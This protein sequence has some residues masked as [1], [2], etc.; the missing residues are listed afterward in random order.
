MIERSE[1]ELLIES[2]KN[3][4]YKL[5]RRFSSDSIE[6]LY[7]VGVVGV[8]YAYKNISM[9]KLLKKYKNEVNCSVCFFYN[10][11]NIFNYENIYDITFTVE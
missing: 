4:I 7:Q 1:L 2:S 8:I 9:V 11:L 10:G 6:D 3:M 5:A